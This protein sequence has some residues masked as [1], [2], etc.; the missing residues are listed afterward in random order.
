[1]FQI[2]CLVYCAVLLLPITSGDLTTW[3]KR[4]TWATW[5]PPGTPGPCSGWW[6]ARRWGNSVSWASVV[7]IVEMDS[8][9]MSGTGTTWSMSRC[10]CCMTIDTLWPCSGPHLQW[11]HPV[12]QM[13]SISHQNMWQCDVN[14]V[15]ETSLLLPQPVIR[16]NYFHTKVWL[17]HDID[18]LQWDTRNRGVIQRTLYNRECQNYLSR[19]IKTRQRNIFCRSPTLFHSHPLYAT[20]TC[21]KLCPKNLSCIHTHSYMR[22]F[23][24]QH[25]FTS[26][27]HL[28]A[29][30]FILMSVLVIVL[31][32]EQWPL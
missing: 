4:V 14:H 18:T 27:W 1:M 7:R 26:I 8:V 28:N 9:T 12:I 15:K 11:H 3:S 30:Q 13:A 16:M 2:L 20:V 23:C 19:H 6:T 25:F 29:P 32:P 5:S 17:W 21:D 24:S 31:N 10:L 22:H